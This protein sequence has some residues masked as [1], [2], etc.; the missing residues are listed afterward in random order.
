MPSLVEDCLIITLHLKMLSIRNHTFILVKAV[1]LALAEVS[2][3][4]V[5]GDTGVAPSR[6]RARM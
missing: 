2:P 1:A 6:T 3:L 4:L 5:R